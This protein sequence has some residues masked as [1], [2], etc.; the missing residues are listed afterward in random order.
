MSPASPNPQS[1]GYA[2]G[3][4]LRHV[5]DERLAKVLFVDEEK[6]GVCIENASTCK[7]R[8]LVD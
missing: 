4:L 1:G 6:G 2:T 7:G 5:A 8:M 3:G